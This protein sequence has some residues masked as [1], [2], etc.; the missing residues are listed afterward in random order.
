MSFINSFEAMSGFVNH[1]FCQVGKGEFVDVVMGDLG[2]STGFFILLINFL[3]LLMR[4]SG[5]IS[6]ASISEAISEPSTGLRPGPSQRPGGA[7]GPR[8]WD[9]HLLDGLWG[10]FIDQYDSFPNQAV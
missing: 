1:K 5:M 10:S 2:A 3:V 6:E 8:R 4:I 9:R 7:A